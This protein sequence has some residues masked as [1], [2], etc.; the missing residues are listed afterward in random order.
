M[1]PMAKHFVTFYS[2]GTFVHE[3]TTRP[4]DRW[5]VEAAKVMASTI[6]E[7]Y[8]ATP[9]AFEFTTRGRG[10]YDLDS[11]VVDRSCMYYLGGKIETLEEIKAR[12]DP[13]ERILVANMEGNGWPRVLVNE[14]SWRV[15][16]HLEDGDVIL[17]YTPPPKPPVQEAL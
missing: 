10:E 14:N 5:D 2:P 16:K 7:R 4:I 15:V 12:N 13:K 9:F 1:A 8:G 3:Q 6:V 17:N 11:R